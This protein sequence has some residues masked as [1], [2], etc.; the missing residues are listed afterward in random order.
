MGIGSALGGI[1]GG[2][3]S[4][5]SAGSAAG[6]LAQGGKDAIALLQAQ[7]K[8]ARNDYAPYMGLGSSAVYKL[9]DLLGFDKPFLQ[10]AD[11]IAK[12]VEPYYAS[13]VIDDNNPLYYNPYTGEA[14]ATGGIGFLKLPNTDTVKAPGIGQWDREA[15]KNSIAQDYSALA[16]QP[17]PSDFGSLLQSFDNSKFEKDPGYQFRLDEGQKALDRAQ[18]ARGNFLSGAA[19]KAADQYN[20]DY[21]SN[22]YGNAYNRYNQDQNSVYN[23]LMGAI[24]VGQGATGSVT[25]N[26]QAAAQGSA[27]LTTQIANAKAAGQVGQSAGLGSALSSVGN[28]FGGSSLYSSLGSTLGSGGINAGFKSLVGA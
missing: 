6:T 28:L 15:F 17:P 11:Q 8:Q 1:T 18:S 10:D 3:L 24:G 14:S 9:S 22:E 5:G 23:K 16:A 13:T 12:A 26:G 19:V 2:L 7:N 4:A 21:A 25:A 27:D 20:Q